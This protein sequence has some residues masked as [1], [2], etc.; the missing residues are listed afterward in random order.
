MNYLSFFLQIPHT[1]LDPPVFGPVQTVHGPAV[2][3]SFGGYAARCNP[4]CF[5]FT[6]H[7]P[8]P[9]AGKAVVVPAIDSRGCFYD[10][11]NRLIV[12]VAL[13]HQPDLPVQT[14]MPYFYG[15]NPNTAC[16]WP[17]PF[18]APIAGGGMGKH[19]YYG[20]TCTS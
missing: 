15:S 10:A 20:I 16:T 2:A 1:Q 8:G 19:G 14:F 6:Q 7:A 13:N 9:F 12:R 18:P 3:V 11:P 5:Q 17:V 4:P